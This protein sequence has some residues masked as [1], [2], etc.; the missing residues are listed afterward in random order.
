MKNKN[1][2]ILATASIIVM[3]S[4]YMQ[5]AHSNELYIDSA[6]DAS[7]PG[8]DSVKFGP[9]ATATVEA[10]IAADVD[11]GE[12]GVIVSP[13]TVDGKGVLNFLGDSF[14]V[15]D[16]GDVANRINKI[17]LTGGATQQVV[18]IGTSYLLGEVEIGEGEF[19]LDGDLHGGGV[20]FTNDGLLTI[21]G[22]TLDG[23]IVTNTDDTGSVEFT[24]KL[25]ISTIG[26]VGDVT[27]SI[28]SMVVSGADIITTGDVYS[29]TTEISTGSLTLG[30]S[31][32]G[33]INFTGDGTLTING[34]DNI[35]GNV[36]TNSNDSGNVVFQGAGASNIGSIGILGNSIK[37]LIVDEANLTATGGINSVVTTIGTGTLTS[38]G[39]ING[40]INFTGDGILNILGGDDINGN[41]E[42]SADGTGI[43][44][45]QGAG[46]SRIG[47]LVGDDTTSL[48]LLNVSGADVTSTGDVYATTT[49][50]DT[51]SFTLG[52]DIYGDINF[53]GDGILNVGDGN[54]INGDISTNVDNTGSIVFQGTGESSVGSVGDIT[55][56]V[57]LLNVLGT[58]LTFSDNVYAGSVQIDSQSDIS[59]SGDKS[60][61]SSGDILITDS[62]INTDISGDLSKA[63]SVIQASG[64]LNFEGSSQIFV[65]PHSIEGLTESGVITYN[66]ATAAAQGGT[67]SYVVNQVGG[68]LYSVVEGA[69]TAGNI[70][71][72]I[73][74]A[75]SF[76]SV[77]GKGSSVLAGVL[78]DYSEDPSSSGIT[79]ELALA[80][81]ETIESSTSAK[82]VA[83]SMQ[84]LQPSINSSTIAASSVSQDINFYNVEHR[85]LA[86]RSGVSSGSDLSL[87]EASNVWGQVFANTSNQSERDNIEGYNADI[88]GFSLGGDTKFSDV[89]TIGVSFSYSYVENESDLSPKNEITANNFLTSVYGSYNFDNIYF[90][91]LVSL[92]LHYY[93]SDRFVEGPNQMAT[94]DWNGI[95]GNVIGKLGYD[96]PL[97]NN[98]V[99]GTMTSLRYTYLSQDD[100]DEKGAGTA[101]LSV[102]TEDNSILEGGIGVK[103]SYEFDYLGM[104]VYPK[105]EFEFLYEFLEGE[106]ETTSS[107]AGLPGEVI[108]STGASTLDYK[109]RVG[110]GVTLYNQSNIEV[111]ID[112]NGVF[113]EDY[114]S[115]TGLVKVNYSF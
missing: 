43:V 89:G 86:S 110:A 1:I 74:K 112:Y 10:Q 81:D 73:S 41:V 104:R 29:T 2:K 9:S 25:G 4:L 32:S 113:A 47:G 99:F 36:T 8:G 114:N 28:H 21:F 108:V 93:D 115:H 107:Y 24:D 83:Q 70:T 92:G 56:S 46:N 94:S 101:N 18:I 53:T 103:A 30:G 72:E 60:I 19:I 61:N 17:R 49:E 69:S 48:K 75:A 91:T 52:G 50:V 68:Y 15:G 22:D 39:D 77:P 111:D 37:S 109:F 63:S 38:I 88:V 7:V 45:F 78:D 23:A 84:K 79:G 35:S 67:G 98:I 12:L 55:N 87:G 80:F 6:V 34:G 42:I 44:V 5:N 3:S 97:A 85:L 65:S 33:D 59:I 54:D 64:N 58:K 40:D 76:S 13:E 105:V 11:I 96:I 62:N 71:L 95:S 90:D 27:N 14:S 31:I 16:I 100:Y 26:S 102:E 82:A 51:G 57:K 106:N 20:T 66:I